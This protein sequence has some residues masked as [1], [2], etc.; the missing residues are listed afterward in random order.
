MKKIFSTVLLACG[1]SLLMAFNAVAG[2]NPAAAPKSG[3]SVKSEE[4]KTMIWKVLQDTH[5][6]FDYD[7]VPLDKVA[8]DLE[9]KT[10]LK[11]QI[12]KKEKSNPAITLKINGMRLRTALEWLARMS[13]AH[14]ILKDN[15]VH[16][17]DGVG[18]SEGAA[19]EVLAREK[20]A[21]EANAEQQKQQIQKKIFELK[22]TVKFEKLSLIDVIHKLNTQF[23]LNFTMD[24]RCIDKEI[25]NITYECKDLKFDE[26]LQA[27]L[28]TVNL[29]YEIKDGAIFIIK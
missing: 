1:I 10:G 17:V 4:W 13:Q 2:D 23:D 5:V 19:P 6:S 12:D 7:A 20:A 11:I 27:M 9:K 25:P 29:R 14:Y 24:P 22:I 8:E 21:R 28:K 15:A 3:E 26:A 18:D 16:F